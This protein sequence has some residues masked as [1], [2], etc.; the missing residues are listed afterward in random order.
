[1]FLLLINFLQRLK[2]F[3]FY[4]IFER[5]DERY[6]HASFTCQQ[7][8]FENKT[9]RN[10]SLNRGATKIFKGQGPN[11][12]KTFMSLKIPYKEV[13]YLVKL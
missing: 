13:N 4:F 12:W 2:A 10:F 3:K 7:F 6:D 9:F 5:Y 1:M 11:F 8:N